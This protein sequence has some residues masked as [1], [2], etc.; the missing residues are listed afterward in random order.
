VTMAVRW[1]QEVSI[2]LKG[3]VEGEQGVERD[4]W[5]KWKEGIFGRALWDDDKVYT[6][7]VRASPTVV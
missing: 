5:R 6:A 1:N 4:T 7:G 3:M 2:E